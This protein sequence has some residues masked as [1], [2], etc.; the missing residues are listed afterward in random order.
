LRDTKRFKEHVQNLPLERFGIPKEAIL[1]TVPSILVDIAQSSQEVMHELAD[2]T[3]S[4]M[5]GGAALPI[6]IGDILSDNG[7]KIY[8][9]YGM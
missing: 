8:S 4:V 5:F 2:A 6:K 9:A 7:V 1:V 3:D